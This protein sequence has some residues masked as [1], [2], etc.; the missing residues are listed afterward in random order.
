MA[1]SMVLGMFLVPI[2]ILFLI[3]GSYKISIKYSE[4]QNIKVTPEIRKKLR[5]KSLLTG[6]IVF[7]IVIILYLIAFSIGMVTSGAP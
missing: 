6:V 2:L 7:F 5:N 3:A 1:I 4:A